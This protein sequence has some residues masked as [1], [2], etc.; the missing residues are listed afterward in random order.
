VAFS[1]KFFSE[2]FLIL[3]SIGI[4][5]SNTRRYMGFV[6]AILT[7]ILTGFPLSPPETTAQLNPTSIFDCYAVRK[8]FKEE[9]S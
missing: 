2:M 8:G 7:K 1:V 3:I 5:I 6:C 9:F 4:I